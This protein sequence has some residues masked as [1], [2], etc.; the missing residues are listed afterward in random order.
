MTE[1]TQTNS[2]V[3]IPREIMLQSTVL[4]LGNVDDEI[5]QGYE[6]IR[7]QHK[8][9]TVFGSARTPETAPDYI[10]AQTLGA[11]LAQE[12]YSVV[13]GGGHGIM[14]AANRGAFE[15]GG[16]SIGFNIRLPHEQ[17]L[18]P[19]TTESFQFHY[20]A[21]RKIVMTLFA[22]AYIYFPGGFGTLDELSEIL[23][24]IQTHK[25]HKAPVILIDDA[26]GNFWKPFDTFV[27]SSLLEKEHLISPGDESLYTITNSIEEAIDLVKANRSYC[28]H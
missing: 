20:F 3:C 18:N 21:P 19:Y 13:T 25:T 4:R 17:Q 2:P 22:D 7:K 10:A 6:I 8:T 12:G 26:D 24:L 15:A 14:E 1:H 16:N 23:T 28:D 11:R 5:R 27:R 9:V